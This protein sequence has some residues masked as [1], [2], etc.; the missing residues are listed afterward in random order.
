M[1]ANVAMAQVYDFPVTR[2]PSNITP[3]AAMR[4]VWIF[5]E[6]AI[7][8]SIVPVYLGQS[9]YLKT[10]TTTYRVSFDSVKE[11]GQARRAKVDV[12][13]ADTNRIVKDH[14]DGCIG[15]SIPRGDSGYWWP[16]SLCT[17]YWTSDDDSSHYI[18][19]LRPE[20]YQGHGRVNLWDDSSFTHLALWKIIGDPFAFEGRSQR[21][22][23]KVSRVGRLPDSVQVMIDTYP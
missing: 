4:H 11:R 13:W 23:F 17:K 15:D 5:W 7:T 21:A 8:D 18:Y 20:G 2:W 12:S 9:F 3:N 10:Y 1:L 6:G 16:D 14:F 19:W 22:L